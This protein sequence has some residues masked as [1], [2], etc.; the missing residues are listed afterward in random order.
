MTSPVKGGVWRRKRPVRSI[1]PKPLVLIVIATFPRDAM[2]FGQVLISLSTPLTFHAANL[3]QTLV[4]QDL[5]GKAFLIHAV[6]NLK[7]Q[8][9]ITGQPGLIDGST[10]AERAAC[11]MTL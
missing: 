1:G 7:A 2:F 6:D 3:L 10:G 8:L 9:F 5:A 4:D 11:T